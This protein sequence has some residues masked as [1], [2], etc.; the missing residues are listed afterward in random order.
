MPV[1]CSLGWECTGEIPE[2]CGE[3]VYIP[4]AL[5]GSELCVG[6]LTQRGSL[7]SLRGT[8]MLGEERGCWPLCRVN[9]YSGGSFCVS[10]NAQQVEGFKDRMVGRGICDHEHNLCLSCGLCCTLSLSHTE[11]EDRNPSVCLHLTTFL[12]L[13]FGFH[14]FLPG[15]PAAS[16]VPWAVPQ[17]CFGEHW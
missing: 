1:P 11:N 15:W 14:F 8:H 9:L 4:A 13:G 3:V 5:L 12:L 2:R 10:E 17:G 16:A 7:V 6:Q